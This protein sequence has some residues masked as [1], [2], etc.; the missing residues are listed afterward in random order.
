MIVAL[1]LLL[2]VGALAQIP[3]TCPGPK[4]FEARFSRFDRERQYM[5]RGALAYDGEGQRVREFEDE[6]AAGNHTTYMKLKLF[7]EKKR[8]PCRPEDP[9]M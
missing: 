4:Q 7:K 1:C 5:V 2:A 8:V 9:Q 3:T 6:H